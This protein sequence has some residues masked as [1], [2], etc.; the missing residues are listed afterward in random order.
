MKEELNKTL[1]DI[2]FLCEDLKSMLNKSKNVEEIIILDF[3]K[4]ANLLRMD[5]D[6]FKDCMEK[7]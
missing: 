3:I 6:R 5:I 7:G 1:D 4:R 2:S